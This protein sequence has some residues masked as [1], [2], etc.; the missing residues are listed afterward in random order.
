M[1]YILNNIK[2]GHPKLSKYQI[3]YFDNFFIP[4]ITKKHTPEDKI[5]IVGD[6][7]YNTNNVSFNLLSKVK[8]IFNSLNFIP[9]EIIGNDYCIDII[10][11]FIKIEKLDYD[12]DNT[13]LFQLSKNDDNNIGFYIIKDKKKFIENKITPRFIKYDIENIEDLDNIEITKDFIELNINGKLIENQQTENKIDLF[14]NNNPTIKAYYTEQPAKEETIEMNN[15]N[16]N[17]RN[18]L[19][20]NVE[21]T[22]KEELE[23]VFTIYDEK[24]S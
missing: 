15:S 18:I 9:I 17:I 20:D 1:I 4:L 8:N 16:I 24:K 19:I 23:E 7:F 3:E 2:F 14:L 6:L 10:G 11:N 13:S 22:L 12:I 5:I 21:K